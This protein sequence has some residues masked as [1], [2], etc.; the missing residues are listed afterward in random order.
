MKLSDNVKAGALRWWLAG[1]CYFFIG[2]GTRTGALAEPLDLIFLLGTGLG[3]ATIF[4]YHPLVYRMF[5]IV[6][7]GRIANQSYFERSGLRNIA[8]NLVEIF[9]NMLIVFLVYIS[10]QSINLALEQV[11]ALPEGTVAV[12]GEPFGFATFYTIY[13]YLLAG[14]LETVG[15]AVKKREGE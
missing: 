6:R 2:F 11:L 10:Y 1:M 7:K 12:P 5:R 3:L 8:F 9:K 13:Y 14:I 15:R 4:L